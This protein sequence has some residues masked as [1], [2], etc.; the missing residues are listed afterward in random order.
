MAFRVLQISDCHLFSEPTKVGYVDINPFQT[1][2]AV[3]TDAVK[4]TPDLILFTGDIS[5]DCSE[6]SYLHL[7]SLMQEMGFTQKIV[8]MIPG[9]HDAPDLMQKVF[10]STS[11]QFESHEDFGDWRLHYLNS[12][13]KGTQ[14]SVSSERLQIL[15]ES[16][17]GAPQQHHIVTVHH[18]P[19]DCIHWM[20]KHD[21]IDRDK[22]LQLMHLLPKPVRVLYGHVHH[23]FHRV[24]NGQE[25]YACPSSCWQWAL[26]EE[27]G[28]SD[29]LPGYRMIE[30]GENGEW[31]T[32][33]NRASHIPS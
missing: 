21:W 11:C 5:G 25:Y 9:N 33:V 6:Q 8:R 1:L 16:I 4:E 23:D 19:L 15:E 20:D 31:L 24:F 30:L 29:L 14:G 7:Q 17:Q 12:H 13:Y 2:R 22:F 18:H 10:G 26:T 3:L 28:V 32:W 27:F